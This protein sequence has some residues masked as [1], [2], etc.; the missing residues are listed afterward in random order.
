MTIIEELIKI[1]NKLENQI[2]SWDFIANKNQNDEEIQTICKAEIL[3]LKNQIS[4]LET[5]I[6]VVAKMDCMFNLNKIEGD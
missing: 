2:E 4:G 5:A 6:G 1:T 3:K